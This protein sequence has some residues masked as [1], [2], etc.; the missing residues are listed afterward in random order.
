MVKSQCQKTKNHIFCKQPPL[1]KNGNNFDENFNYNKYKRTVIY[2]HD[3]G[4]KNI[5]ITSDDVSIPGYE[6]GVSH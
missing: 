4:W 3:S 6:C 5:F 1:N 2:L